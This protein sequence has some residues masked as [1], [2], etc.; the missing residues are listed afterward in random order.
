MIF[1][2]KALRELLAVMPDDAQ[3]DLE[4]YNSAN[5]ETYNAPVQSA[6]IL[7]VAGGTVLSQPCLVLA[8]DYHP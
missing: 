4:V 2:V 7:I 6:E 8:G 3:I 1:N 5:G